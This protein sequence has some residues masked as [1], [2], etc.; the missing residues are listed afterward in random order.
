[1][2][3]RD[4]PDGTAY[5][6]RQDIGD[7]DGGVIDFLKQYPKYNKIVPIL[8]NAVAVTE[9]TPVAEYEDAFFINRDN[10]SVTWIY[11]NPDSVAGGQYVTNL[12]SYEDIKEA[13]E[14]ADTPETFFDYLGSIARQELADVG[15]DW[16]DDTDIQ[17]HK[18]P[19]LADCIPETM[20]KLVA[21]AVPKSCLLYTSRCV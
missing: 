20:Q 11:Y 9:N 1:M 12:I 8:E 13:G 14:K 4:R 3:I 2:C 19:D 18:Q 15:S 5:T 6:E 10:E 17:F 16:F 21:V 7:G